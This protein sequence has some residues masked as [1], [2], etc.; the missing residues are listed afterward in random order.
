MKKRV[1]GGVLVLSITLG[2]A[3]AY[4]NM[5]ESYVKG[6]TFENKVYNNQVNSSEKEGENLTEAHKKFEDI[7]N[8]KGNSK[9]DFNN[10]EDKTKENSKNNLDKVNFNKGENKKELKNIKSLSSHEALKNKEEDSKKSEDKLSEGEKEVL[11]T[12]AIKYEDKN[13]FLDL[14]ANIDGFK[15]IG[16]DKYY[17]V[18]LYSKSA[19][20]EDLTGVV[21]KILINK[22]GDVLKSET[23]E[24][25]S[26][27]EGII[28]KVNLSNEERE[29]I[30]NIAKNYEVSINND[31]IE[32]K[33]EGQKE[34]NGKVYYK[35]NLYL[36][37][38]EKE[39][40]FEPLLKLYISSDGDVVKNLES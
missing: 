22:N 18:T 9:G 35:S 32:V 20:G 7:E 21:D 13:A 36:K 4:I 25:L 38:M 8:S 24:T 12:Y 37:S 28:T 5:N 19:K 29:T 30:E 34:M 16:N 1:I 3:L 26:S 39:G 27:I 14:G 10:K 40:I 11:K 17:Q 6:A 31:D 15:E 2:G 23:G 33:F